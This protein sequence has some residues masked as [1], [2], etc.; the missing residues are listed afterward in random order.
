MHGPYCNGNFVFTPPGGAETVPAG[1]T[2][3][4][5]VKITGAGCFGMDVTNRMSG[6]TFFTEGFTAQVGGQLWAAQEQCVAPPLAPP[7]GDRPGSSGSLAV[8]GL[9]PSASFTLHNDAD[10]PQS[11]PCRFEGVN[12]ESGERSEAIRLNDLDWGAPV[13]RIVELAAHDSVEL[14]VTVTVDTNNPFQVDQILLSVDPDRDGTYEPLAS[15]LI[16]AAED[17]TGTV[18]GA[19]DLPPPVST[20]LT[21]SPNPFGERVTVNLSLAEARELDLAVF[22]V[23]GRR[24]QLLHSGRLEAGPHPFVWNGREGGGSAL[25]SGIYFVRAKAPGL[26]LIAKALRLR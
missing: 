19:Q 21:V 5:P 8:E 12:G 10:Q 7:P 1:G 16:E 4:R 24:V 17:S 22:D 11:V 14:G 15:S 25:K 9:T 23:T 26:E 3:I 13:D 6:N 18:E 2:V 20:R